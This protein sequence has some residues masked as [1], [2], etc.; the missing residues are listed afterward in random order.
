MTNFEQAKAP[1]YPEDQSIID[2]DLMACGMLNEAFI[3]AVEDQGNGD[4]FSWQSFT[5]DAETFTVKRESVSSQPPEKTDYV[6]TYIWS[7]KFH[8]RNKTLLMDLGSNDILRYEDEFTVA[9]SFNDIS[10]IVAA[11]RNYHALLDQRR[12]QGWDANFDYW[13]RENGQI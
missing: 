12:S 13:L 10:D 7:L 6:Q 11:Y 5:E 9:A 2:L 3:T 8:E 1:S 4:Q